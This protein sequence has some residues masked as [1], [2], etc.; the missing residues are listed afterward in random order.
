MNRRR[1]L[2]VV[3]IAVVGAVAL[4]GCQQAPDTAA[5][6]GKDK[7]TVKQ[8]DGMVQEYAEHHPATEGKAGEAQLRNQIVSSWLIAELGKTLV[9]DGKL[10]KPVV[11]VAAASKRFELAEN[12]TLARVIAE[13]TAY[14]A[15]LAKA[16]PVQP[17][18]ADYEA[19]LAEA[20]KMQIVP[21][22]TKVAELRQSLPAATLAPAIAI[23]DLLVG[24][25][26]K[27]TTEVNPKFGPIVYGVLELQG[28]GSLVQVPLG[29]GQAAVT[30]LPSSDPNLL[31]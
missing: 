13:S 21:P 4:T 26:A 10:E 25:Q 20:V 6:V 23:R 17:T 3:T 29:S 8:V 16:K 27:H 24:A 19:V 15:S 7:L 1:V 18:E 5:Y 12:G 14:R 31:R 2:A 30:D 9:A 11:D 28:G 22:A